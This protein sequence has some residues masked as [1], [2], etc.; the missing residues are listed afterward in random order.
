MRFSLSRSR[1]SLLFLVLLIPCLSPLP[2]HSKDT[3]LSA[4][5]I[6]YGATSAGV[7]A[8]I[9]AARNGAKVI[10]LEPSRHLGG[11]L[12]GGLSRTDM[13]RQEHLIGGL[14]KEFFQRVG[15]HYGQE[16]AWN[17]EPHVAKEV[18]EAIYL[19]RRLGQDYQQELDQLIWL[20]LGKFI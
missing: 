3:P 6:I 11:M 19:K 10:L 18:L 16:I 9:S 8:A 14:A 7:T 13:D 12:S 2:I 20:G 15:R 5:V 1:W 4:D 17:F